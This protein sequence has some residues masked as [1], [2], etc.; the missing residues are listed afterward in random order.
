[1]KD[2]DEQIEQY[3]VSCFTFIL[4]EEDKI[5]KTNKKKTLKKMT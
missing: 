1:M 2:N 5:K 3:E 4:E